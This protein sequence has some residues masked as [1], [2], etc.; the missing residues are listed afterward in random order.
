MA[1]K[2]LKRAINTNEWIVEIMLKRDLCTKQTNS[3]MTYRL[4]RMLD[5][6]TPSKV[7]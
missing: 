6:K 7:K 1:E 3:R 2:L 5:I 4:R